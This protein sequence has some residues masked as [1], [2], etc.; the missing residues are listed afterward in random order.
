MLALI[1]L[2]YDQFRVFSIHK[3]ADFSVS[4]FFN[5]S[6]EYSFFFFAVKSFLKVNKFKSATLYN[7]F[8]TQQSD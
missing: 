6:I 8:V 7:S 2:I 3:C 4:P 5:I 1:E